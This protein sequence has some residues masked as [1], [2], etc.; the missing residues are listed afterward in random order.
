MRIFNYLIFS[1]FAVF[2]IVGALGGDDKKVCKKVANFYLDPEVILNKGSRDLGVK[3]VAA[4]AV[5]SD[6]FKKFYFVQ[7]KM[8]TPSNGTIYPMFAMNKPFGMGVIYAMDELAITI[9]D[10]GDGRKTK[11]EFKSTNDGF[12]EASR[13]LK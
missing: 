4:E 13:C 9:S 3:V 7:Y 1:V 10:F 11:A 8:E 5:R 2:V 12:P 6:D